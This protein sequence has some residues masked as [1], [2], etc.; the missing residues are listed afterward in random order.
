[1]EDDV[2][3][4]VPSSIPLGSGGSGG[5][6]KPLSIK[7]NKILSS[8]FDDEH[9]NSALEALAEICPQDL[10][11]RQNL[12]GQIERRVTEVNRDFLGMF[13]LVIK[14]LSSLEA[15]VTEMAE[16][17][18][19]M[20]RRLNEASIKTSSMLEKT[21]K[22][23]K[24]RKSC[25]TRRRIIDTFLSHFTLSEDEIAIL[26]SGSVVD[27]RFFG[28]LQHLEQ[29]N[30]D[31]QALLITEN[32]R[33]GIEIM[34]S[35]SIYQ[36][37]AYDKL[38]R[39]TQQECRSL[40]RD[41]LEAS[42]ALR[43]AMQALKQRPVLFQS[44]LDELV[45]IRKNAILRA[46]ID[47]LTRGGP[48]GMPR[49]IELHAHDPLRYI[50]DMLAWIHQ[51]L[52]G[53]REVL[54][55][56]FGVSTKK[57]SRKLQETLSETKEIT[58]HG[59]P[60]T[61][62]D[63]EHL[64]PELLDK[65]MEASCRPLKNRVE[66]VLLSELGAI[67][68]YRISKLIQFY[69]ITVRNV[70]GTEAQL[71]ETLEEI[72]RD[73]FRVF[74]NTLNA[75]ATHMLR[76]VEAP[77]PNLSPPPAVKETILQ[78]KEIMASHNSSMIDAQSDDAE[79]STSL[80]SILDP[81]LQMCEMGSGSLSSF[82]HA[83]YI[84]N[85]LQS[86]QSVLTLYPFTNSRSAFIESQIDG[87]IELLVN[88]L[89]ASLLKQS[90]LSPMVEALDTKNA[91]TPLSQLPGLDSSSLAS[92]LS[93]LDAFLCTASVDLSFRLSCLAHARLARKTT[94]HAIRMFLETY[95]RICEAIEN[96][97]NEYEISGIV[98]R[99]VEE[100]EELLSVD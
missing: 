92:I 52:V 90:G 72:T 8:S 78:L 63:P 75:R 6:S 38:Y 12:R 100:V 45:Q 48:G 93:Q 82:D 87:H 56:L 91:D 88:E 73:S 18:S 71:S 42:A 84:V 96:P 26:S 49:P 29:I 32:Q 61:V 43:S 11:T 69:T 81:L 23:K 30:N 99:R 86:V 15:E 64:I 35:M 1:M 83:I 53:E 28:A 95:R 31:C 4:I 25:D 7:L 16:C 94:Q 27:S 22:L 47:A 46:F 62:A 55:G 51:S 59:S 21:D 76:N 89:H 3:T 70:F 68:A 5:S 40:N 13:E 10:A 66:Q 79:F 98:L 57:S 2:Q 65:I 36:E 33:A 20:E 85:C 67:T 9:I 60:V 34:E 17:C 74:T 37:N 50:G 97:L 44:C 58:D 24:E 39:W 19:E 54:E 14:Q 77:G 80:D 41:F